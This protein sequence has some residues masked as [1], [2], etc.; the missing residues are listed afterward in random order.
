MTFTVC[1]MTSAHPA[2]D[3][4]IFHKQCVSLA[5]HGYDVHLVAAG[6]LTLDT[7]GVTHHAIPILPGEGRLR[8]MVFRSWRAYRLATRTNADLFHF[9]D[10]ELLPYGL[11]LK[12]QGKV[13]I[14]DAHEDLPRDVMTKRWIPLLLRK[15]IS[16][17][18]EI[19]EN[20]IARRLDRVVAATPFIAQRF[21]SIG[22]NSIDVKNYPKLTEFTERA[23]EHDA[24][25]A[26]CYVGVISQERGIVEMI[27]AIEALDIR[28]I[29]AGRFTN[30]TTEDLARAL[31]GWKKVD[32]RGIVSR[33]EI[34]KIFAES[35]VGLCMLH[36]T[37]AF[38]DSLPIKLFEYMAAG[39]PVLSSNFPLWETIIESAECG[40]CID[41]KDVSAIVRGLTLLIQ[42]SSRRKMMGKLGREAAQKSYSWEAEA[43]RLTNVYHQVLVE[44]S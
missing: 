20:F 29:L 41:P 43:M 30:R 17:T 38:C 7:K 22:A 6:A 42:S 16:W 40:V 21:Q 3:I 35:V 34:G 19:V 31:P 1:H 11:L 13:V 44:K 14:Y 36:P 27:Q 32:Y 4:R 8:R 39:L 18:I 5:E 24:P 25:P 2:D 26:V 37:R 10:P 23:L 33:E 28:L 12:W 15:P 9:H